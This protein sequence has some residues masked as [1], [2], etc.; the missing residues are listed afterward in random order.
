MAL[1]EEDAGVLRSTEEV[2]SARNM[3]KAGTSADQQRSIYAK[4]R[5]DG[6]SHDES[7]RSVVRHLIEE[8]RADL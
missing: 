6:R 5:A 3:V 7:L 4:C 2:L 8:F 1:I